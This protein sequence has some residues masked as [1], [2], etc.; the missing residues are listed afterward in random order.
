MAQNRPRRRG[1]ASRRPRRRTNHRA[2]Q[3]RRD[4]KAQESA[5]AVANA[6]KQQSKTPTEIEIPETIT[7]RDLADM[8]GRSPID[9]IK[10]LMNFGVMAAINQTI[11][12]DTAVIVGEEMGVEVKPI[13][14]EE[15]EAAEEEAE[16]A[17]PKTL[18]QKVLESE[19]P[20]DLEPRPP[21][22]T[23]LGHVD[24]GKTTLLDAIRHTHVVEGEAGGITQH[25]GAYQVELDGRKITFLDTPGHEAFTAMRARGAQV[26]DL[27]VLVVAADDGVM[28]QTREALD[29]ARAA[30]VPII[31]ALT[32]I[33]KPNANIERVKQ[34]LADLG[35]VP[36]DWG[37]DTIMVP[38]CA[39][40][41]EGVQELLE[42][43]LLVT[44]LEGLKANPNRPAMGTVIESGLDRT[45]GPMATLLVQNGTLHVGDN[46][47]VGEVWG[48]VRAM[49]DEHGKNVKEATPATPVQVTGL[50]GVPPAG[51]I[52]EVVSDERTAR[53]IAAQRAEERQQRERQPTTKAVSLED[54]F[55]QVQAG[56]VKDLN[57]ILKA[58]VQGSLEPIVNSLQRLNEDREEV[59]LR[60]LHQGLGNI[61]ES[62]VMLAVASKAIVIGFNVNVDAAAHRMA[63]AEGVEIRLYNV[64]YHL[65]E[66][67]ERA[68]KGM[69]EPEFE[70]IVIGHAEVRQVFRIPRRGKVAGCYVTDGVVTRNALVR[71]KRQGTVIH[72]GRVA[73]LKRF[74]EDVTEVR[75]DFE[76]GIALE[77][78]DDFE[79]GDI[80]EFCRVEQLVEA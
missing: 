12:F 14:P 65:I 37:G 36:E 6:E 49:F 60:I 18:W 16:L 69:M 66:D 58:D 7:V 59:Q 39:T 53:S 75:Q 61:S 19:R 64:I 3:D 27:V 71:V 50:S 78:F 34:Q 10:V 2:R 17:G 42:N 43:I 67:I 24:H 48:R 5:V 55:S 11:D 45:R 44:E 13:Q 35:L 46:L 8:M 57:L 4:A 9:V 15:P 30:G 72:E 56:E 63:E 52:F 32:K 79:E 31:V 22:V 25:I 80:L 33:D 29:H 62:D 21:V 77:G 1:G 20:E 51:A 41:G 23:V 40:M 76:C 54:I 68:L 70:E 28:P 26:T 74:Q 38:V 47:V 73:S